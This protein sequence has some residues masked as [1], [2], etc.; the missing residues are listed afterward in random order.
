MKNRTKK[1]RKKEENYI[2]IR[3]KIESINNVI[4]RIKERIRKNLLCVIGRSTLIG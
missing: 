4:I 2:R 1:L 3:K